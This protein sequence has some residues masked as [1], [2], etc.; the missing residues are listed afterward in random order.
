MDPL[1]ALLAAIVGYLCGSISFA[2][3][4]TR[5]VAIRSSPTNNRMA[6]PSLT[7]LL[8]FVV[9]F[10]DISILTNIV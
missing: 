9:F 4:I 10:C 3:L 8:V 2:R 6:S 7:G 1:I 5:I